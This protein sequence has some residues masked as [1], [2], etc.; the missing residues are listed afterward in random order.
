MAAALSAMMCWACRHGFPFPCRCNHEHAWTVV[1]DTPYKIVHRC[2]LCALQTTHDFD[3]G[4][5]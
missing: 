4:A 5:Y 1:K 2:T 3:R